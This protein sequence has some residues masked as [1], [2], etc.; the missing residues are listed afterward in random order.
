M[1]APLPNIKKLFKPD[2]GYTIADCDLSGADAQ[3]V[4]WEADDDDLK[5]AFRKG[6]KIHAKNA[7]DIF[8]DEFTKASGDQGNK[9]TPKGKLYDQCKRGV[10]ATNYGAA[11]RTLHL[12]PD[13]GWSLARAQDF[14]RRWFGLHPGIEKWHQR[15]DFLLRTQRMAKNA[16]GY[17]IIFFD[18]IDQCF[19]E[20]LAWVPQSTVALVCFKGAIRL[21]NLHGSKSAKPWVKILC[22]VHDSLVFQFPTEMEERLWEIKEAIHVPVPYPD[23]LTIPF[24]LALSRKS[25]GDVEK[26][27]WPERGQKPQFQKAA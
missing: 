5:E 20:A 19:P 22:Q 15:T 18:R 3:V 6:M 12:N 2:P 21:R 13:I 14:Q 17:R 1:P 4:A 7:A 9:A 26:L 23:P 10:H 16:Y 27:P 24:G 25:W 8:G 11:A